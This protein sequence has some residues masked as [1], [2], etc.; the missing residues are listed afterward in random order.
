MKHSSLPASRSRGGRICLGAIWFCLA[1]SFVLLLVPDRSIAQVPGA[2][3][4]GRRFIVAFPDT[5]AVRLPTAMRGGFPAGEAY[6]VFFS[7]RDA[8]VTVRNLRYGGIYT[9]LG[10]RSVPVSP[11]SSTVLRVSDIGGGGDPYMHDIGKVSGETFELTSDEPVVLYVYY[12][13]D[14]G[15]EAFTPIPVERWG[16][17]YVVAAF[18]PA[19]VWNVDIQGA[20]EEK[21][22]P[23][24]A[25]VEAVII[26]AENNT[27]V[28]ISP[29][30]ATAWSERTLLL[31][32]GEAY[33]LQSRPGTIEPNIADYA[34]YDISGTR[35][36]ATRP[37]AVISGNTR[38]PGDRGGSLLHGLGALTPN[39]VNNCTMEW[40]WPLEAHG[41]TFPL[42][43]L[44]PFPEGDA[45][46]IV[47]V[48]G[49]SGGV[50]KV[51]SSLGDT[52]Y[53]P[54]EGY[55][56][57]H[58]AP[59]RERATPNYR[60][61]MVVETDPPAQVVVMTGAYAE[62]IPLGPVYQEMKT[63]PT[64]ASIVPPEESWYEQARF[65]S[66]AD[67]KFTK[68]RVAITA[69]S[70]ARVLLDG[71]PVPLLPM[72]PSSYAH[73]V[74]EVGAGDHYLVAD[75]GRFA[76]IA[77]GNAE[78][79]QAF[80]PLGARGK[81]D[82]P[83]PLH[84]SQYYEIPGI[85]YAYPAVGTSRR[86][87]QWSELCGEAEAFLGDLDS[88]LYFPLHLEIDS[89]GGN[90]EV[91][92]EVGT[93]DVGGHGVGYVRVR[94]TPV[95][96][97]AV[98]KAEVRVASRDTTWVI[99]YDYSGRYLRIT[100]DP[101]E[102]TDVPPDV[103]T[104][105]RVSTANIR[106][107]P[108]EIHSVRLQ[109]NYGGD[110]GFRITSLPFKGKL[111]SGAIRSFDIFFQGKSEEV[112][113]TDSLVIE[114]DCGVMRI[115][116]VARTAR[117]GTPYPE[118]TGFDAGERWVTR[119]NGCTKNGES[120]YDTVIA[121]RN[122]GTVPFTVRSIELI[123]P[124]ADAG[125]FALDDSDPLL[126]VASGSVIDP[127]ATDS[128]PRLQKIL[129][130]PDAE[131]NYT[132]A[133]RLTTMEGDTAESVLNGVGIESH[134][135][136]SGYDFGDVVPGASG[137]GPAAGTAVVAAKG[138]R[139]LT[140]TGLRIIGPD[141]AEFRFA[142]DFIDTLPTPKAP[143]KLIPG[144]RIDLR[145]EFDP[146]DLGVRNAYIEVLG[147]HSRCDDSTA[148]LAGRAGAAGVTDVT[149]AAPGCSG[150]TA[151]IVLRNEW[152]ED[153]LVSDLTLIDP[154]GVFRIEPAPTG[155]IVPGGDSL[156]VAVYFASDTEGVHRASL[157]FS[158]TDRDGTR[159]LGSVEGKIE[160][161]SRRV[162]AGAHIGREFSGATGDAVVVPILLDTPID[163]IETD[164]LLISFSYDPRISLLADIGPGAMLPGDWNVTVLKETPG[165]RTVALGSAGGSKLKGRGS[166]LDLTFRLFL[167][168][169]AAAEIP[170]TID[171]PGYPCARVMTSPGR[172]ALD[173]ICGLNER[174]IM[175]AAAGWAL[176]EGRPNPF[177][178][179]TEILYSVGLEGRVT[180][181][182]HDAAGA[183]VARPADGFREPGMHSVVWDATPF[184]SGLYF[185]RM[186]SESWSGV[187][188]L[189]L[190]K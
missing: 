80:R 101:V 93:T 168:D 55:H 25:P 50:T 175:I 179:T 21:V 139:P 28:T 103:G 172:L 118:I 49:T 136:V 86:G 177:N 107:Y 131:R 60:S 24:W 36:T 63:G 82:V 35:I 90:V 105:V 169:A 33:Q 127:A 2:P 109:R 112:L 45:D 8:T 100:P 142:A 56:D 171:L 165:H 174:L 158:L 180:I 147:D 117:A 145:L 125:H 166:L 7:S 70:A 122:I 113:Y 84:P 31:Q 42:T 30:P 46:E 66:P 26:A 41:R 17:E 186:R 79:Y 92:A 148:L 29:G 170:F 141:A 95:D 14:A 183:E 129:F 182:I 146:I 65:H 83:A 116:L 27:T 20:N 44:A 59:H 185:C 73:A 5:M 189:F 76:A 37:I 188:S 181:T 184:P 54:R 133:V 51:T 155:K 34:R 115:P 102:L 99:P 132:C 15:S 10:V 96:P 149:L 124:D 154:G 135:V 32:A 151:Y 108:V 176:E 164:T 16:K 77:Y 3:A 52:I 61:P 161:I 190:L 43:R 48:Y 162:T 160:G 134:T 130:R 153:I 47:R 88:G 38:A 58:S 18:P 74:V 9:E 98:A 40:L 4:P 178:P 87:I 67:P 106:S 143:W 152:T 75:G 1:C 157:L 187:R 22:A 81:D 69:E 68:H 53:L 91:I 6:M 163:E 64:A 111:D 85:A 173:S 72:P 11:A 62:Y 126:T 156:P 89:A 110:G 104:T 23:V 19:V 121:V 97:G 94:F 12:V 167:G 13:T 150:D 140:V 144:E 114:T 128:T 137:S 71:V 57:F 39:T 123:G 78:G 138:S 119:M 159:R 120:S